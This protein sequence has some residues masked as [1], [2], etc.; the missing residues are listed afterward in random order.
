MLPVTSDAGVV[1]VT[2]IDVND[3]PVL[4]KT[5]AFAIDENMLANSPL[6]PSAPTVADQDKKNAASATSLVGWQTLQFLFTANEDGAFAIDQA[7]PGRGSG[8]PCVPRCG[9][10]C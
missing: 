3:A 1:Y 2:V 8:R 7:R 6:A 10:L 9:G 5:T 4:A